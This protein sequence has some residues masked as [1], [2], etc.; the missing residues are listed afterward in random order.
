VPQPLHYRSVL[1]CADVTA[2]QTRISLNLPTP[3]FVI[4]AKVVR[5]RETC[6][7]VEVSGQL[8]A[9]AAVSTAGNLHY[10]LDRRL[11][12]ASGERGAGSCRVGHSL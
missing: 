4:K 7:V 8:C 3:V 12:S 1:T 10:P 9:P 6:G 2:V 11:W 5:R